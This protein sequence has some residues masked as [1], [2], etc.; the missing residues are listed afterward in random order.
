MRELE[1]MGASC[2]FGVLLGFLIATAL[3]IGHI[4]IAHEAK[5]M[6]EQCEAELPRNEHC[7]II[8]VREVL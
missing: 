8:A 5:Y 4:T 7:V 2:I 3:N 6:I 1:L